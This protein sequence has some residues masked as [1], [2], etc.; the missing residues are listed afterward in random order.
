M[1]CPYLIKHRLS[2]TREI[3]VVF[4]NKNYQVKSFVML[5]DDADPEEKQ[6][7][8]QELEVMKSLEP[9]P[10]VVTLLGCCTRTGE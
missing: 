8:L 10:Y 2:I 6:D 9:H 1:E 3:C 5:S 7:F 4:C